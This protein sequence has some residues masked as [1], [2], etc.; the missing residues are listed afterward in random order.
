MDREIQFRGQGLKKVE[1]FIKLRSA[2]WSNGEIDSGCIHWIEVG[3][4]K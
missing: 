1:G 2:E 4:S 3:W